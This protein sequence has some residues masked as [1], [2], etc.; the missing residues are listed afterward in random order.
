MK[1]NTLKSIN[2]EPDNDEHLGVK[3]LTKCSNID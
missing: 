1:S 2:Y 3:N